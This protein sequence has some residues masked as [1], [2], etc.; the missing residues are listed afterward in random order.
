MS[1]PH[2]Q[3]MNYTNTTAFI[4]RLKTTHGASRWSRPTRRGSTGWPWLTSRGSRR[5]ECW[6]RTKT[7]CWGN[8]EQLQQSARTFCCYLFCKF[9]SQ[10]TMHDTHTQWFA[11][12]LRPDSEWMCVFVFR[13]AAS[14]MVKERSIFMIKV[15]YYVQVKVKTSH[16]QRDLILKVPF[17]MAPHSSS[18]D[19]IAIKIES[20]K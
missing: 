11:L 8:C 2:P 18:E 4:I 17:L 6:V 16:L 1:F 20:K 12:E 15:M 14:V 19:W 9:W 5:P 10:V 7:S 13:L 3:F